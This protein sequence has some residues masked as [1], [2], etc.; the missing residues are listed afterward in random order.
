LR[1]EAAKKGKKKRAGERLEVAIL[2]LALGAWLFALL[3]LG[4]APEP[5]VGFYAPVAMRIF[6]IH[7]PLAWAGLFGYLLLSVLGAIIIKSERPL[8]KDSVSWENRVP[9]LSSSSPSLS[10]TLS[11]TL[12]PTLSS[13]LSPTLSLPQRLDLISEGLGNASLLMLGGALLTGSIWAR[14]EWGVFWRFDDYKLMITLS[15]FLLLLGYK[16]VSFFYPGSI[17]MKAAFALLGIP[18]VP[19]VFISSRLMK[20]LHPNVVASSQGSIGSSMLLLAFG[21]AL[22]MTG[23]LILMAYI[24]YRISLLEIRLA[25]LEDMIAAST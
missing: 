25:A 7:L 18:A 15:V 19:L 1:K 8:Q 21:M 23:W 11:S 3:S 24:D 16:A 20:S 13:T 2:L 22:T 10:S 17:K 14:L 12:S 5:P 4:V 6:Y 9:L